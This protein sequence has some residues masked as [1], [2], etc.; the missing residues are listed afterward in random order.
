MTNPEL[1]ATRANRLLYRRAGI[2]RLG[3]INWDAVRDAGGVHAVIDRAVEHGLWFSLYV[4]RPWLRDDWSPAWAPL[5]RPARVT[6]RYADGALYARRAS[7]SVVIG[8]RGN[9]RIVTAT[10]ALVSLEPGGPVIAA[11]WFG[12]RLRSID[13]TFRLEYGRDRPVVILDDYLAWVQWRELSREP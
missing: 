6:V 13:G 8:P 12:G 2:R 1:A 5:A 4:V 7:E 10:E 9:R 3:N 11:A